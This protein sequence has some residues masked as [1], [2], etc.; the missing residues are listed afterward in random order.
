MTDSHNL[1]YHPGR[2]SQWLD[3]QSSSSA[4]LEVYPVFVEM[5]LVGA[6][7]HRCTFCYSDHAGYKSVRLDA[8]LLQKRIEEMAAL[9]VKA[10]LFSGEGEPLLYRKIPE[11]VATAAKHHVA[12]AFNSNAVEMDDEFIHTVLPQSYEFTASVNAGTPGTYSKIHQTKPQD[13]NQVIKHLKQAVAFRQKSAARFK[14]GVQAVLLPNNANEMER[15]ANICR[16]DIGLDY[17]RI[18]SHSQNKLSLQQEFINIDY[19]PFLSLEKKLAK[20]GNNQFTIEFSDKILR[21]ARSPLSRCYSRCHATPFFWAYI[22]ADGS[23]YGCNQYL[24]DDR[25]KYGNINFDDFQTIWTGSRRQQAMRFMLEAHSL[26][27]CPSYCRMD[28]V[29][30]YLDSLLQPR[31]AFGFI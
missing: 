11:I 16:D 22:M 24:G 5:S 29:N 14:L 2:V 4:L 21:Q 1:P 9:G 10:I 13:F 15:L 23:V 8:M 18:V 7:N 3:A 12:V 27:D 28:D 6:C 30:D 26:S 25:F 20:L 17:L 19:M 31:A